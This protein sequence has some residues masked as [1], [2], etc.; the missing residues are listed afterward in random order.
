VDDDSAGFVYYADTAADTINRVRPDGSHPEVLVAL[1]ATFGSA[2]D[3]GPSRLAADTA[4]GRL[5]WIDT[6]TDAIYRA[7]LDGSAPERALDV[8]ALVPS[9]DSAALGFAAD[10]VAG[11]PYW[12]DSSATARTIRRANLDG[13]GVELLLSTA[14]SPCGIA[15]DVGAGK[16]YWSELAS[17]SRS[18][19]RAN[20]DGSGVAAVLAGPTLSR[21]TVVRPAPGV[22]VTGWT[23]LVTAEGGRTVSF[24]VVLTTQPGADVVIPVTTGDATEGTASVTSLTFTP[25]NWLVALW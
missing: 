14:G 16:M 13:T 20:L 24:Q 8:R 3:F 7:G 19:R 10:F 22:S 12:A 17:G 4:A 18:V 9:G 23:G 2:A 25:A 6:Y 11:K 21:L 15:L 5:Y 1:A